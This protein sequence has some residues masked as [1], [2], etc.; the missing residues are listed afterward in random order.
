MKSQVKGGKTSRRGKELR[1]GDCMTT[2]LF[3]AEAARDPD[4][5]VDLLVW[6][7]EDENPFSVRPPDNSRHLG[8]TVVD[9]GEGEGEDSKNMLV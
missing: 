8:C 4:V 6:G 1:A 2:H 9:A 5:H 3:L 7:D